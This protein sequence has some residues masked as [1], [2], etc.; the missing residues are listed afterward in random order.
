MCKL[1]F[2]A[3]SRCEGLHSAI[4]VVYKCCVIICIS[5]DLFFS[6]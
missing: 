2:I 3:I 1:K 5:I 4:F 6:K